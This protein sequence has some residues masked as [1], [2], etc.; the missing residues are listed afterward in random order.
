MARINVAEF[1]TVVFETENIKLLYCDPLDN[2]T[3]V[4]AIPD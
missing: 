1:D 4:V 3:K 2:P